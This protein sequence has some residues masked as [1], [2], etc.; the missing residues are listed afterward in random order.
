MQTWIVWFK[1]RSHCDYNLDERPKF[2]DFDLTFYVEG[3]TESIARDEAWKV[4][5]QLLQKETI[6]HKEKSVFLEEIAR[7]EPAPPAKVKTVT[8]NDILDGGK[9]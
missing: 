3:A 5:Q 9:P 1:Y 2:R 4:V 6:D 8:L 7:I